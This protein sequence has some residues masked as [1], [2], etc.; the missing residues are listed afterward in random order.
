MGINSSVDSEALYKDTP[1]PC[2][3]VSY[4]AFYKPKQC[5]PPP[6][7]LF[8][9]TYRMLEPFHLHVA[10]HRSVDA[11]CFSLQCVTIHALPA[12]HQ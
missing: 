12:C 8:L 4:T 11:A 3:Y 5:L 9:A 6:T 7:V 2:E 10:T 1:E